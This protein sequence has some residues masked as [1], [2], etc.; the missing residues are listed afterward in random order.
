MNISEI[1]SNG[2]VRMALAAVVSFAFASFVFQ[3]SGDEVQVATSSETETVESATVPA[4]IATEQN[5]QENH[6]NEILAF[7]SSKYSL[8]A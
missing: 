6:N 7:E 1:F 4:T 8:K 3:A 5:D 2:Y